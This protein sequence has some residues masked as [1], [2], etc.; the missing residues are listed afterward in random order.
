MHTDRRCAAEVAFSFYEM[1][2]PSRAL[3]SVYSDVKTETSDEFSRWLK[4]IMV[5]YERSMKNVD[6][7]SFCEKMRNKQKTST[8]NLDASS[9]KSLYETI[10]TG[11][12]AVSNCYELYRYV[13]LEELRKSLVPDPVRS[14]MSST[15]IDTVDR[16]LFETIL[17]SQVKGQPAVCETVAMHLFAG[18]EEQ[19]NKVD[20]FTREYL[21]KRELGSK[22]EAPVDAWGMFKTPTITKLHLAGTSGTG[23]SLM[24]STIAALMGVGQH[25]KT[26]IHVPLSLY[27]DKTN[28]QLFGSGRGLAGYGDGTDLASKLKEALLYH[29]PKSRRDAEHL[30]SSS[31]VILAY[32]MDE[33]GCGDFIRKR[34]DKFSSGK[35]RHT[36]DD[37]YDF[38]EA[39]KRNDRF[40]GDDADISVKSKGSNNDEKYDR[41]KV[42]FDR[43]EDDRSFAYGRFDVKTGLPVNISPASFYTR[44]AKSCLKL[45]KL[46]SER[47]M[48]VLFVKHVI[49]SKVRWSDVVATDNDNYA[50]S[51]DSAD[52]MSDD[53]AVASGNAQKTTP[54]TANKGKRGGRLSNKTAEMSNTEEES[55][56]SD[57]P[58]TWTKGSMKIPDL[59]DYNCV[60]YPTRIVVHLD[61]LDKMNRA[62][63]T[64]MEHFLETGQATSSHGESFVLPPSTH[65]IIIFTSNFGDAEIE[66]EHVNRKIAKKVGRDR[67]RADD[68]DPDVI[69]D[70]YDSSSSSSSSVDEED[71]VNE[72]G[73][74]VLSSLD[75]RVY[76]KYRSSM[77]DRKNLHVQCV[78]RSMIER[79][80]TACYIGR[81]GYIVPYAPV[82]TKI[83]KSVCFDHLVKPIAHRAGSVGLVK[84]IDVID[85]VR[86]YFDA[87]LLES[88]LVFEASFALSFAAC[89]SW[90]VSVSNM[91]N[92]KVECK[93]VSKHNATD[94]A[95]LGVEGFKPTR[96]T[97]VYVN[98]YTTAEFAALLNTYAFTCVPNY[99]KKTVNDNESRG[100]E[101]LKKWHRCLKV[102]NS[103]FF[104]TFKA[105][106]DGFSTNIPLD[107]VLGDVKDDV[108]T[109]RDLVAKISEHHKVS[110]EGG[111][112]A[113]SPSSSEFYEVCRVFDGLVGSVNI[114]MLKS[115]ESNEQS[116]TIGETKRTDA[117][118]VS[119]RANIVR[120]I[121]YDVFYDHFYGSRISSSVLSLKSNVKMMCSSVVNAKEFH[122]MV[123]YVRITRESDDDESRR[124]GSRMI[125]TMDGDIYKQSTN[126]GLRGIKNDLNQHIVKYA[127]D[128]VNDPRISRTK[129]NARSAIGSNETL[130]SRCY[131][132]TNY[133]ELFE[134]ASRANVALFGVVCGL[135]KKSFSEEEMRFFKSDS[136]AWDLPLKCQPHSLFVNL[137][138]IITNGS[139]VCVK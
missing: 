25:D 95:P 9:K 11:S 117:F 67:K 131:A 15:N 23:K 97:S 118:S 115:A 138:S 62:G 92:L 84:T 110:G 37:Y 71:L 104:E 70:S 130:S 58:H 16:Y 48:G 85:D 81:L 35:R 82:P 76:R 28:T 103:T 74:I 125:T 30:V 17:K 77:E 52:R 91:L 31:A 60:A 120:C 121:F 89:M 101:S 78:K 22:Y 137:N 5:Q 27:S 135:D 124:H 79:K 43:F 33:D 128:V 90:F 3:L 116:T 98:K 64:V 66:S 132:T 36:D 112:G 1:R 123:S 65:L 40:Y 75:D 133:S 39:L 63:L 41:M 108:A 54:N 13:C 12:T 44:D 94:A 47:E 56:I 29:D 83:M 126:T 53:D 139:P 51:I 129:T 19:R 127:E 2:E 38:Y 72:D 21:K 57:N 105:P 50:V 119:C 34:W 122:D 102:I 111:V 73:D 114:N 26:Y 106:N 136:T 96:S 59:G 46:C 55:K 87:H 99:A 88:K 24:G 6:F 113:E 86:S 109:L 93:R 45:P 49:G 18:F 42:F 68:G 134:S 107:K 100:C 80:I 32:L 14:I 20:L 10:K 4:S 61:E 69:V 8:I 7:S